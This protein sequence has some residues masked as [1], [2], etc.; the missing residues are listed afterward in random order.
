MEKKIVAEID[1]KKIPFSVLNIEQKNQVNQQYE[2]PAFL[3]TSQC[4]VVGRSV[5]KLVKE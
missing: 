3:I 5:A 1:G 4:L 2:I